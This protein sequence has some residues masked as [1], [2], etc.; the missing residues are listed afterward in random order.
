MSCLPSSPPHICPIM[1]YDIWLSQIYD[2]CRTSLLPRYLT[3]CWLLFVNISIDISMINSEVRGDMNRKYCSS[4][5]CS[6]FSLSK[7]QIWSVEVPVQDNV[8]PFGKNDW[9]L[10]EHFCIE[11]RPASPHYNHDGHYLPGRHN[12]RSFLAANS[13][14]NYFLI[15]R[16]L[17]F[18]WHSRQ[19]WC[20]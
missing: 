5:F 7:W 1:I 4:S 2:F 15:A 9:L 19:K 14:Q 13:T 18:L 12:L 20:I 8:P 17:R 10:N 16:M 3:G 11:T 6:M